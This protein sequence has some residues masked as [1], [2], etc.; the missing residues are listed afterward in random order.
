MQHLLTPCSTYARTL[1]LG[2]W[3]GMKKLYG[4]RRA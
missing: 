2:D 4:A 1:G 3:L